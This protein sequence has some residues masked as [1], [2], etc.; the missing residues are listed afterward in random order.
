MKARCYNHNNSRFIN[1]GARG[2]SIT[3][4][5]RTSFN[6]FISDMGK[7]PTNKHS[8]DRLDNDKGYFKENCRWATAKEQANNRSDNRYVIFEGKRMRLQD[9]CRKYDKKIAAVSKQLCKGLSL[10]KALIKGTI[11]GA[12]DNNKPR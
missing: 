7:K 1:Y 6:R 12:Y 2:I 8:L 5:W 10:E 9:L 3:P 11:G 4:S